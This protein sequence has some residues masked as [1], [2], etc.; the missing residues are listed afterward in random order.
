MRTRHLAARYVVI[1]A[2]TLSAL[3]GGSRSTPGWRHAAARHPPGLA[4][5]RHHAAARPALLVARWSHL[6]RRRLRAA[7]GHLA[8]QSCLTC[9][10]CKAAAG[11]GPL[12]S[13]L[14]RGRHHAAAGIA[15]NLAA[16]PTAA[17]R[18]EAAARG[19]PAAA[20]APHTPSWRRRRPLRVWTRAAS[21][22]LR[23]RVERRAELQRETVDAD[24][25]RAPTQGL[26]GLTWALDCNI[27]DVPPGQ[28]WRCH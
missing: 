4:R 12:L 26:Q 6:A 9:N 18:R 17:L 23:V 20:P 28:R 1:G 25:Q 16:R 19:A 7:A 15:V 27:A 13:R 3:P 21:M 22:P 10:W 8:R 24:P 2:A 14:A 5:R 11:R